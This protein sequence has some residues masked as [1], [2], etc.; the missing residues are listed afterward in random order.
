MRQRRS[1]RRTSRWKR[2]ASCSPEQLMG[3][4]QHSEGNSGVTG[5]RGDGRE[6]DLGS[7]FRLLA[8]RISTS[9]VRRSA[10]NNSLSATGRL[11]GHV[12][13]TKNLLIGSSH[14]WIIA[15]TDLR[16]ISCQ[17]LGAQQLRGKILIF[18]ILARPLR[19][20]LR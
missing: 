20:E 4:D 10:R 17:T 19:I 15:I 9:R 16:E 11:D 14:P 6:V 1:R 7:G 12:S 2:G 3:R 13:W 18:E 8:P 5:G